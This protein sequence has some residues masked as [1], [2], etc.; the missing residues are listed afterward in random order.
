[1][2]RDQE[3]SRTGLTG[4]RGSEKK[5]NQRS[6]KAPA[7]R[8]AQNRRSRS[9]ASILKTAGAIGEDN[10]WNRLKVLLVIRDTSGRVKN[11]FRIPGSKPLT[12]ATGRTCTGRR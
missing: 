7:I 5:S 1:M 8:K 4:R 9:M 10:G 3:G 6:P 2:A 11:Y 12:S